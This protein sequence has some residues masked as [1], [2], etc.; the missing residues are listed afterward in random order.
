ME[1]VRSLEDT[2]YRKLTT[3]KVL[4]LLGARR[5]GKSY[6]LKKIREKINLS[7]LYLNGE[8]IQTHA[9]LEVRSAENYK[10]LLGGR[11]LLIIDEAQDIPDIGK[12][13]KLMVD[14][15][16][17]LRIIITGS[18]SFD[19]NN[20]AG[21]PLVGRMT[22]LNMFPM[23][24]SELSVHENI[25]ETKSRLE[26]RLIYGS[27]PELLS[28]Q[29]QNEKREYLRDIIHAYL[30]KDILAYEG[31]KR[32]DKILA[33]LQKIS[34]RVGSE[35]SLEALG[36]E[37][38]IS[39]NSVERYLDLLSKVFVIYPISGFSKN[40][41]NEIV[42][43]KKWFFVDNGIRN[44]L[45]SNFNP[46]NLRNDTG[47]LWENYLHTERLK[48]L[49]YSETHHDCYFWRTHSKQE[50]DRIE[51]VNDNIRAFEFKWSGKAIKIPSQFKQSYTSASYTQ[52]NKDN[53]LSFITKM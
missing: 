25:F 50:I 36:R 28:L 32:S 22:V 15:I 29:G 9:V 23:A 16:E 19:I 17:N 11:S 6:L 46:L 33:L 5:V 27:Y 38:Q 34:F 31:I 1:Y 14:E 2:I 49:T 43:L 44:G 4:M 45:I 24:Q 30:L 37:L 42:K 10:S 39:K 40:R 12:K 53:Y 21:E 18:S 3:N 41:D 20:K 47:Q 51:V 52:I 7:Y 13:L 48:Y 8:D 26:D 35:I